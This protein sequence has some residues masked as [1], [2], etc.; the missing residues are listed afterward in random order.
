MFSLREVLKSL[1][2]LLWLCVLFFMAVS[3]PALARPQPHL[4]QGCVRAAQ[5]CWPLGCW[6]D[7]S[8]DVGIGPPAGTWPLGSCFGMPRPAVTARL[9]AELNGAREPR[10]A[11][12]NGSVSLAMVAQFLGSTSPAVFCPSGLPGALEM[13]QSHVQV[14]MVSRAK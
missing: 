4:Y 7:S 13:L 5:R 9:W 2:S 11:A 12:A 10:S 6:R 14:L 8:G 3:L 1:S